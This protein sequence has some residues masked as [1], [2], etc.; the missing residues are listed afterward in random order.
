MTAVACLKIFVGEDLRFA[1]T[2]AMAALVAKVAGAYLETTWLHPRRYGLVAPFTFVLADP[3]ATRLDARELQAMA[4]DMQRKLFGVEGDGQVSLLLVEGDQAEVMRFGG[5]SLE[6]VRALIAQDVYPDGLGRVC[7]VTPDGVVSLAPP[8]G[9]VAG[10]PPMEALPKIVSRPEPTGPLGFRGVYHLQRELFVGSVVVHGLVERRTFD[11]E[12][13]AEAEDADSAA[14]AAIPSLLKADE[15][16]VIFLPVCFSSLVKPSGRNV[17]ATAL[18]A[19]PSSARGRLAAGIYDTPRVPSF[20][21]LSQIKSFLDPY[22][23]RLDL[24]VRDPAFR[25]EDL[26]PDFASSVTLDLPESTESERLAAIDR[27][28]RESPAYRRKRIWQ[29]VT[30]VARRREL[31]ACVDHEVPFVTGPEV[32][33]LLHAPAAVSPFA[34]PMLPLHDW[35]DVQSLDPHAA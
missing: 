20:S 19:L 3:R 32:T 5:M 28:M 1:D 7:R 25:V 4:R 21:A 2:D 6:A 31:L 23:S 10:E 14:L 24:R 17:L 12:I 29:G 13:R 11:Q 15:A 16:G 18:A 34:R 9:P 30:G 22:V 33:D 26:P 8:G 27:F 35:H